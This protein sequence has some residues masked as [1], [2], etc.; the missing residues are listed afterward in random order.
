MQSF[1][2]TVARLIDE[3][4]WSD[5]LALVKVHQLSLDDPE[6][7]A[8]TLKPGG[9]TAIQRIQAALAGGN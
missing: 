2:T 1:L 3:K 9:E 8:T 7:S 5:V 6:F 4:D